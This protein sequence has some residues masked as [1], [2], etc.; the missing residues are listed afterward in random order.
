MQVSEVE[1]DPLVKETLQIYV[2]AI[3]EQYKD[4]EYGPQDLDR[5]LELDMQ[6]SPMFKVMADMDCLDSVTAAVLA[7]E[8]VRGWIDDRQIMT[9]LN[10]DVAEVLRV[11]RDED[12]LMEEGP[13]A[14]LDVKNPV[15]RNIALAGMMQMF[16]GEEFEEIKA[17]AP[18]GEIQMMVGQAGTIVADLAEKMIENKSWE[19]LPP[20]LVDKF[21][22]GMQN[23][24]DLSTSKTGKRLMQGVMQDLK[25]A[26]AK[27]TAV[28]IAEPAPAVQ[29]DPNS[30][31][32]QLKGQ[33]K[34]FKFQ[35]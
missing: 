33:A 11:M 19:S 25:E 29:I 30:P 14:L 34:K 9:K 15:A 24:H 27:G 31:F 3:K 22:E 6:H 4:K 32:A 28:E 8:R 21:I 12:D 20:K 5:Y 18:A 17:E 13:M 26:I 7:T 1:N 10:K 35:Q 16:T 2:D 23:L